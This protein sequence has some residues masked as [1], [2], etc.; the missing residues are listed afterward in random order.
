MG[1]QSVGRDSG[2]LR[3]K[4]IAG[5]SI[6]RLDQQPVPFMF[7]H[8]AEHQKISGNSHSEYTQGSYLLIYIQIEEQ[9]EQS[10][11]YQIVH[12][13]VAS[14]SQSPFQRR[15]A[16]EREIRSQKEITDKTRHI[17]YR[18]QYSSWSFRI[19]ATDNKPHNVFRRP[20]FPPCNNE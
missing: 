10:H 8:K 20:T 9:I 15:V 5:K 13:M 14:K 17:A 4:I 3:Q 18:R 2:R 6:L 16:T 19:P 11:M 7:K 1:N 12:Q